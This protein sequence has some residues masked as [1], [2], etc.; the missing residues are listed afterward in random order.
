VNDVINLLGG[1]ILQAGMVFRPHIDKLLA[2]EGANKR[3]YE[4]FLWLVQETEKVER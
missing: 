1:S 3:M 4:H 2:E